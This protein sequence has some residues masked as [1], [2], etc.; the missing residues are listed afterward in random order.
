M[1]RTAT[2]L[3]LLTACDG[4]ANDAMTGA[5]ELPAVLRDTMGNEFSTTC[6]DGE[7]DCHLTPLDLSATP[8]CNG[9]NDYYDFDASEGVFRICYFVHDADSGS[10]VFGA[11]DCRPIGCEG[12]GPCLGGHCRNGVCQYGSTR[13]SL[14][15]VLALCMADVPW[16]DTCERVQPYEL[17]MTRF[18]PIVERCQDSRYDCEVPMECPQ[19]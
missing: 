16:P 3:L 13:A 18:L 15:D 2:L 19:R 10:S 11:E 17:L 1:R 9:G 14:D 5:D 8:V 12:N 4:T 6:T 7:D